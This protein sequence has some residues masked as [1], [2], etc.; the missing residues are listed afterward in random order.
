MTCSGAIL[1]LGHLRLGLLQHNG[2]LPLFEDP[3]DAGWS[4][5]IY[6]LLCEMYLVAPQGASEPGWEVV[7]R[8]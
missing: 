4:I 7:A 6:H 3:S 1:R 8:G 2:L 5:V